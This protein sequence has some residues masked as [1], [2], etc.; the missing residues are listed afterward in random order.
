MMIILSLT[1]FKFD[2]YDWYKAK[3]RKCKNAFKRFKAKL[4]EN[5]FRSYGRINITKARWGK[6]LD[7]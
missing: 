3:E 4:K 6:R 2:S 7:E 5:A 1:K